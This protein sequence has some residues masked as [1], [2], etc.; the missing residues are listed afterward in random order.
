[1]TSISNTTNATKSST[2]VGENMT[3]PTPTT[4]ARNMSTG[5]TAANMTSTKGK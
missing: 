4:A 2:A 3:S 1:M 5:V